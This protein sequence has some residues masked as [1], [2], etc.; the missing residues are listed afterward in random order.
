MYVSLAAFAASVATIF[1]DEEAFYRP[2]CEM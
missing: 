2:V 1:V